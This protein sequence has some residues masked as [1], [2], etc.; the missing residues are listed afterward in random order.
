[1]AKIYYY[2]GARIIFNR[3]QKVWISIINAGKYGYH[4]TK[5]SAKE[6]IREE[7]KKHEE[8]LKEQEKAKVWL[9]QQREKRAQ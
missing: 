4:P 8:R 3:L 2:G 9:A 1:M 7:N 5:Q 6:H